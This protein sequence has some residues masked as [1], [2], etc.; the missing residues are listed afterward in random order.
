VLIFAHNI[1]QVQ[2]ELGW[3]ARDQ[4]PFAT[5]VAMTRSGKAIERT[6]R[7]SLASVFDKPTP[8][9]TRGTFSTSA[10]KDKLTITIG[11][12]DQSTR[13]A[14]PALYVRE[15]FTGRAR[16]LKPFER[17]LEA[18]G[19][20]PSG[21]RAMPGEGMKLDRFG[22]PDRNM[23]RE[24]IGAARSGLSVYSK[25]KNPMAV[26][27]FVVPPDS[28]ARNTRHLVAGLYRRLGRDGVIPVFVYV[29]QANYQ[30]VLDLPKLAIDKFNQVFPTEFA[31]ALDRA[32]RTRRP[33]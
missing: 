32:I 4:V 10:K 28:P 11:M 24:V 16:G 21:W 23:V 19:L 12:R 26:G 30:Q 22:N 9:I 3:I 13:G 5:A 25:R 6:L 18:N 7:E 31:I 2:R 14:S 8:Y 27:Y 15:H 20:L 33:R 29:K 1:P 17:A